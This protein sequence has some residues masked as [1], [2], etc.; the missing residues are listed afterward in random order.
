MAYYNLISENDESTVV[1]EFEQEFFA[2]EAPYMSESNLED[3][4]VEQFGEMHTAITKKFKKCYIFGFTGTPIF[5]ANANTTGKANLMTTHQ[6]FG[7]RLHT[8]TIIN[9]ISDQ[10]VLPF[11][12]EYIRT[13]REKDGVEDAHV[14]KMRAYF[15][16]ALEVMS[17]VHSL[18]L[19]A[20]IS[21][22]RTRQLLL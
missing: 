2:A 16:N 21:L 1:A 15:Y 10:N 22:Y 18:S 11:H 6:V 3:Q 20:Q 7:E 8:Y 14:R 19:C 5:S 4:F 13:M 17:R 12:L 9:A